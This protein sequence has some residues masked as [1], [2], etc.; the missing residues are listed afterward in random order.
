MDY[1]A[2]RRLNVISLESEYGTLAELARATERALGDGEEPVTASYLS[3][4]KGGY[5][6]MGDEVARKVEKVKPELPVGWM[7]REYRLKPQQSQPTAVSNVS[8][9][10]DAARSLPLLTWVSA[11]VAQEPSQGYGEADAEAWYPYIGAT[12]ADF[13][14][15]VRGHSMESSD[16]TEPTYPDGCLILVSRRRKPVNGNGVI[17]RLPDRDEVTFKRFSVEGNIVWL[18]PINQDPE[19]TSYLVGP[20]KTFIGVVVGKIVTTATA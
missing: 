11:G 6:K 14:L 18:R 4:I 2:I 1:K 12:K 20:D 13:L 9:P 16:G 8:T 17:Y 10:E 5:R 7:D 15:R 19:Y 3:Q